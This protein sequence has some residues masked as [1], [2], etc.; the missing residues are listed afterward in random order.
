MRMSPKPLHLLPGGA[1][2]ALSLALAAPAHAAVVWT[3]TFETGDSSE[4]KPGTDPLGPDGVRKNF[5]VLG[6]QVYRGKFAGKITVHPDDIFGQYKQD[7]V[8][9]QHPSTLTDEGKNMWI[10]GHYM[11]PADAT[12]RNEFAFF[13]SNVSFQ[14]VMDF[15]V[16]PKDGGGTTVNF[17]VGFLGATKLW[18]ADFTKGVWHQVAIHVL[19]STNAQ[20][21]TV[22]VW[23]DGAQVITA[24]KAKTK[25]DG[26]TLFFQTGLHRILTA[27]MNDTI[28]FDDFIEADSMADAGIAAPTTDPAGTGGGGSGGMGGAAGAG[29]GSTAG[30]GGSSSA[31]GGSATGGVATTAGTSSG[32]VATTAAAAALPPCPPPAPPALPAPA[33]RPPPPHLPRIRVAAPSPNR[34]MKT[35]SAAC[36]RCSGSRACYVVAAPRSDERQSAG[37]GTENNKDLRHYDVCGQLEVFFG[38]SYAASK[39]RAIET[40]TKSMASLLATCSRPALASASLPCACRA[41]AA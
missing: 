3:S 5:E 38:V 35:P 33:L 29:G 4:W 26:N 13:E 25:A 1:L 11:M 27:P 21:G 10:S 24:A 20:T 34:R 16:A 8:D 32:G 12:V 9:I 6:E 14:N 23:F 22:D 28:Y 2:L 18:T 41:I 19:W 7:R 15:W 17:G 30:A 31:I 40:S 36:S 39:S 37:P